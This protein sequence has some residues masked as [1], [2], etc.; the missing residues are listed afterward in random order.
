MLLEP[1]LLEPSNTVESFPELTCLVDVNGASTLGR[2]LCEVLAI[3]ES[4]KSGLKD[5]SLVG[6]ELCAG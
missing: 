4:L 2:C 6:K 5:L 1:G 3:L